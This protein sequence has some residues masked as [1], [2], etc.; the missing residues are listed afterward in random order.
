MSAINE[1][2]IIHPETS[3][4]ISVIKAIIKAMKIKFEVTKEE[5]SPYNTE[6]VEKIK[7]SQ[8]NFKEGKGR[9]VTLDELDNLWK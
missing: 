6:F 4:Q 2:F 8:K 7:R 1:V 5:K 9:S 3:E